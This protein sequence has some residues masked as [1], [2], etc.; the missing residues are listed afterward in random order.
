MASEHAA[1]FEPAEQLAKDAKACAAF[2]IKL[3]RVVAG[4]AVRRGC[5]AYT[6]RFDNERRVMS[7]GC[8][9]HRLFHPAVRFHS[10]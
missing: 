10:D 4:L 2:R 6:A 1:G 8:L 9:G 7:G 5:R 3:K